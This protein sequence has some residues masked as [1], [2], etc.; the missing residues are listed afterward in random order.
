MRT[1]LEV[2]DE[3]YALLPGEFVAHRDAAAAEVKA[4]D[5]DLARRVRALS[6][7]TTAA[8]VVDQLVRAD[9]E[10]VDQVLGVG[11]ALR[12]AQRSMSAEELRALT[13]QRRQLTAAVTQRARALARERGVRVS[14][15]VADRV[16]ATL[17]AAVLD[18]GCARAVRSG[19]L[20][21]ALRSTGVEASD[22]AA[23][24]AVPEA[25]GFAATARHEGVGGPR[26]GLRAVPDAG[27][28]TR[29]R[30]GSRQEAAR[31]DRERLRRA[32][33]QEVE[34]AERA[35]AEAAASH[36]E[37]DVA[38][39]E[40]EARGLQLSSELDELRRRVAELEASGEDLDEDLE[41]AE[42]ERHEAARVLADATEARD[43]AR[44]RLDR[45]A[46]PDEPEDP[47]PG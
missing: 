22:V 34:E 25:L 5:A 41:D 32:A 43:D 26:R 20:V 35:L 14:D 42:R 45:L 44:A 36:E 33:Q 8:W 39:R 27:A 12:E 37:A 3:L 10:E 1:L 6:K 23:A 31:E 29:T 19:L 15:E 30:R 16:E 46:D 21:T 28:T 17:T 2:A 13:R 47:A 11:E 24:L 18:A 7:P 40:L 38:V 9:P 4:H